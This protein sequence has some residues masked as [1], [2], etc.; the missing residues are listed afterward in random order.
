MPAAAG[1]TTAAPRSTAASSRLGEGA[2]WDAP[3][4]PR[5]FFPIGCVHSLYL[6]G[7]CRGVFGFGEFS[8]L[9]LRPLHSDYGVFFFFFFFFFFFLVFFLVFFGVKNPMR[10]FFVGL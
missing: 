2:P 4:F 1:E 10:F 6:G 9:Y 7:R 3:N 8:F 5:K